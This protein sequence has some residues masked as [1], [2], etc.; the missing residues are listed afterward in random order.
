MFDGGSYP[1]LPKGSANSSDAGLGVLQ[2]GVSSE[3][4]KSAEG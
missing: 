1:D 2:L 4:C 3:L